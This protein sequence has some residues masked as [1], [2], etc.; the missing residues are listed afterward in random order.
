MFRLRDEI[1]EEEV[2]A[3]FG[4]RRSKK[5]CAGNS[6]TNFIQTLDDEIRQQT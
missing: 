4:R 1:G 5:Y 6:R 2:R 3:V